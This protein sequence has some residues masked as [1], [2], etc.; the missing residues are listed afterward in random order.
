M[1]PLFLSATV[2]A[3]SR[4]RAS[5]KLGVH[6][7]RGRRVVSPPPT[8][9]R[10]WRCLRLLCRPRILRAAASVVCGLPI[11]ATRAQ[12]QAWIYPSFQEPRV[13]NREFTF[14]VADG[15]FDGTSYIF[16]WREELASRDLFIFDGGV[17]PNVDSHA[18]TFFSARYGYQLLQQ[19]DSEAF[20]ALGTVGLTISVGHAQPFTRIPF[21]IS[22]GHRF[23]F[24]H[25]LALTAYIHPAA[26]LDFCGGGDCVILVRGGSAQFGL[27][28]SFGLGANLE[29]A[30]GFS[31]RA[32]AAFNRSTVANIDNTIGIGVAWQPPGLRRP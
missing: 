20:E 32:E 2:A 9:E 13:V 7:M 12:A 31:V 27:G 10:V 24:D 26:S 11:A 19:R 28:A 21:A 5:R 17:A 16:Q 25:N 18:V 30:H 6:A 29:L 3:A 23:A 14:A 8:P 4:S 15:G 22:L 1:P